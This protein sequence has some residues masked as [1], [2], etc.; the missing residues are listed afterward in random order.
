MT[1]QKNDTLD[2]TFSTFFGPSEETHGTGVVTRVIKGELARVVVDE[3]EN[4]ARNAEQEALWELMERL[5]A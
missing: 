1:E 3:A 4:E 5:N 2:A